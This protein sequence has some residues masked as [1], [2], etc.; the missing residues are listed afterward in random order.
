MSDLDEE[1]DDY[2]EDEN[3]EEAEP[4][5]DDGLDEEDPLNAEEEEEEEPEPV[6]A[7]PDPEAVFF[8]ALDR[9]KP[10][11]TPTSPAYLAA[12]RAWI[13][14]KT[15]PTTTRQDAMR[16]YASPGWQ[17]L[18]AIYDRTPERK[19]AK[20][21]RDAAR[22]VRSGKAR[23]AARQAS[24]T[25]Q[26]H[27]RVIVGRIAQIVLAGGDAKALV[28]SMAREGVRHALQR[29]REGLAAGEMS[30]E[31]AQAV[32]IQFQEMFGPLPPGILEAASAKKKESPTS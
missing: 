12:R 17:V 20:K 25:I 11:D 31:Q 21:E 7:E 32:V 26:R 9:V 5:G 15:E 28:G 23:R 13:K 1:R 27:S 18:R 4:S 6:T 14:Y 8:A 3:S 22:W 24:T 2:P 10:T 19:E 16:V 29:A 30:E